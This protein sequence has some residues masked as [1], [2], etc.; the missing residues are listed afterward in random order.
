LSPELERF[1][2]RGLRVGVIKEGRRGYN[3]PCCPH[4]AQSNRF[5]QDARMLKKSPSTLLQLS[6]A[7][8]VALTATFFVINALLIYLIYSKNFVFGSTAGNWVYPYFKENTSVS[9]WIPVAIFFLLSFSVI[10]GDKLILTHEKITLAGCFLM[11]VMIQIL[12]HRVYRISLEELVLSRGATSFYIPAM[13]YSPAEILSRFID[14]AP[15]FPLHAKSNMPGKIILFQFFKLFTT[16]P[17][18]MGYLIIILS[19]FGA[20]LLYGI[21]VKLF[22]DRQVGFYA[23]ILYALIPGKLVHFPILNTI[24]PVFILLCLFLFLVYL[25][26]KQ[27]IFLWLL[28]GALYLLV[29]FEPS[30]LVTGIIFIGIFLHALGENRISKNDFSAILLFPVLGFLAVY[31]FFFLFFS[32]NM[33]ETF[34]YI[35]KAAVN[36]NVRRE[37]VYWIW[38]VE[39]PKEFFYSAGIPVML[40]YLYLTSLIFSHW[41]ALIHNLTRWSIEILFILSLLITFLIVNFLGINRGEI[42]RLWIYLAVFFQIPAAFFF[43]K[44]AKSKTLFFFVSSSLVIQSMISLL[45]VRFN[46]F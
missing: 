2:A 41:K 19:S 22:H 28:G 46:G 39:N 34:Q 33:L 7:S 44:M 14:L 20:P 1:I 21:C 3:I 32:F 5:D 36:F 25:E 10:V 42:T 6:N 43:G 4:G 17:Q 27:T 40:I 29:F 23:F 38:I 30:P 8:F 9:L 37:R 24:T 18:I 35:L 13:Q 11:V 26:R 31:L 15:S 12:I 16:S 45:R